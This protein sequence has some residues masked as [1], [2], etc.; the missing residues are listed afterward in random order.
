MKK[1]R[2]ERSYIIWFNLCEISGTAQSIETRH[3]SVLARGQDGW[4]MGKLLNEYGVWFGLTKV[5]WNYGEALVEQYCEGTRYHWIIYFK[6]LNLCYI[7]FTLK[8][9]LK[10]YGQKTYILHT[11]KKDTWYDRQCT[12]GNIITIISYQGNIN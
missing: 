1:V 7:N 9:I 12:C 3:R 6:W 11:H 2:H 8:I 10:M 5:L 4:R